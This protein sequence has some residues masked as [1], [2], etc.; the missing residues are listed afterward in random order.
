MAS[1]KKRQPAKVK[2]TQERLVSEDPVLVEIPAPSPVSLPTLYL[3][4]TPPFKEAAAKAIAAMAYLDP[5]ELGEL[6]VRTVCLKCTDS[7]AVVKLAALLGTRAIGRETS[8]PLDGYIPPH[9][10]EYLGDAIETDLLSIPLPREIYEG[11][12]T[13]VDV[14][15]QGDIL[16]IA[17]DV[18]TEVPSPEI[19]GARRRIRE[20]HKA[21]LVAL[22]SMLSVIT[23]EP[24][25]EV[26]ID[27][28]AN[29]IES[30]R[31]VIDG[32]LH[33]PKSREQRVLCVLALLMPSQ[34]FACREFARLYGGT[35]SDPHRDFFN[36]MRALKRLLPRIDWRSE[37]SRRAVQGLQIVSGVKDEQLR[38][39]LADFIEE[40]KA[41]KR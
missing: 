39:F 17:L 20:A 41:P 28:P 33:M 5:E 14:F 7:N 22:T 36:V 24:P 1:P 15:S 27:P 9:F 23:D 31:F 25:H 34:P 37:D 8:V 30:L 19:E 18:D 4:V 32:K 10:S 13:F 2:S 16:R 11:A 40:K 21:L 29:S 35:A 38:R 3:V 12:K 26:R 6:G